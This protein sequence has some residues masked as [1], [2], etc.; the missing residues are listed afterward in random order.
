M[1]SDRHLD[2]RAQKIAAAPPPLVI[3]LSHA[4]SREPRHT[5]CRDCTLFR[6]KSAVL[7]VCSAPFLF[8]IKHYS[9]HRH[10]SADVPCDINVYPPQIRALVNSELEACLVL[11]ESKEFWQQRLDRPGANL[12]NWIEM[13]ESST[14]SRRRG[15]MTGRPVAPCAA[16]LVSISTVRTGRYLILLLHGENSRIMCTPVVYCPRS[17][18]GLFVAG[19]ENLPIVKSFEY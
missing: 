2:V 19:L 18:I 10:G 1:R 8:C 6:L 13:G 16:T 15:V 17:A 7:F 5:G 3:Y 14:L 9:V 11:H 12:L 4:L